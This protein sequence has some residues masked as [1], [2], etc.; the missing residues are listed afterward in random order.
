MLDADTD[1][2]LVGLPARTVSWAP[3][4]GTVT[5]VVAQAGYRAS[6]RADRLATYTGDPYAGGCTVVRRLSAPRTVLWRSC[7]DRVAV[8]APGGGRMFTIP[9]LA[10][11]LGT[12]DLSLRNARTGELQVAYHVR[13]WFGAVGWEAPGTVLLQANGT[14]RT[15]TVRCKPVRCERASRVVPTTMPRVVAGS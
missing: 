2:V 6:L 4:A 11:G 3:G 14:R 9:I 1:R 5:R 10:D 13:G 7:E 8:F 15:A 12:R